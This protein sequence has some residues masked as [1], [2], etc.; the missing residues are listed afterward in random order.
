MRH[1]SNTPKRFIA[2]QAQNL[3]PQAIGKGFTQGRQLVEIGSFG[4]ELVF[5][6]GAGIA[7]VCV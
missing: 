1:N 6:A 3:Q 5:R 4:A 2:Q 7:G